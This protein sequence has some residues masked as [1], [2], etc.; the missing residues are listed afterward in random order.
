MENVS[1]KNVDEYLKIFNRHDHLIA[2]LVE[3]AA[4]L[5]SLLVSRKKLIGETESNKAFENLK[6]QRSSIEDQKKAIDQSQ[7]LGKR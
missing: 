4:G 5:D 1:S 6:F 2:K 7:L 3:G